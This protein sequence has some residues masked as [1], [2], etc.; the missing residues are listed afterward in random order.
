MIEGTKDM[1]KAGTWLAG[2]L[3]AIA[4]CLLLLA[5]GAALGDDALADD[6]SE[7]SADGGETVDDPE[8]ALQ[9]CVAGIL[10]DLGLSE[11]SDIYSSDSLGAGDSTSDWVAYDLYRMGVV[12]GSSQYLDALETY[13][14]QAYSTDRLLSSS[15]STE[16]NRLT[17]LIEAFG[18]DP[19]S[20]GTDS[21]G[22]PVDLVAD[23]SYNWSQTE[24][25]GDQGSNAYI[26]ALEAIYVTGAEVPDDALYSEDQIIDRL[27]A[28]QGEDGG[29][30]LASADAEGESDITAMAITALAPYMDERDDVA[31]A[32]DLA[33]DYLSDVQAA[34]GTFVADGISSSE[35]S[36]MVIIALSSVGVDAQTDE[37]FVKEYGNAYSALL[38]YQRDDGTFSHNSDD[39]LSYVEYMATEQA[40]R[41]LVAYAEM[42]AGGDGNVYTCDVELDL[43][44]E[45]GGSSSQ[46]PVPWVIG[47]ALVGV[48]IVAVA[49]VASR[50]RRAGE[51]E[52]AR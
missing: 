43:L 26:Y 12:D 9:E 17:I 45:A 4:I 34:D 41:A 32:I 39:D 7:A 25:L 27:L 13:V 2:L 20:F 42:E 50:R 6:A 21:E 37:R 46:S 44:G 48:V 16:W 14:T 10:L 33:L 3:L 36:S 52:A 31:E 22:D 5:P 38:S 11:A 15:K 1:R 28:Y 8:T 47:G 24:S 51:R 30:G 23:G 18:G 29:F 49:V 19:T 40:M 35:S